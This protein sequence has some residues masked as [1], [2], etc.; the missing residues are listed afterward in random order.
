MNCIHEEDV[1]AMAEEWTRLFS[2][3]E[4]VPVS[5][6]ARLKKR[7]VDQMGK[8]GGPTWILV[9][10]NIFR[11]VLCCGACLGTRRVVLTSST[12]SCYRRLI[13]P[14]RPTSCGLV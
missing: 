8:D 11:V 1:P 14:F 12:V 10:G 13:H 9:S 3:G 7:N 5:F 6:E 4:Y 2:S